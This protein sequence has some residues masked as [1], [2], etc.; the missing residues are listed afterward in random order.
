[1]KIKSADEVREVFDN[2][3]LNE[4][5][6]HVDDESTPKKKGMMEFNTQNVLLAS[7]KLLSI[8][9]EAIGTQQQQ[10]RENLEE[11]VA[12]GMKNI[13][14]QLE[15]FAK[16]QEETQKRTNVYLFSPAGQPLCDKVVVATRDNS[17]K[18]EDTSPKKKE[19]PG[20]FSVQ[21]IVRGLYVGEVMCDLGSIAIMMLLSLFNK[22]GGIEAEG[23]IIIKSGEDYITYRISGQYC[24]LKQKGVPKE[25]TNLKID[26]QEEIKYLRKSFQAFTVDASLPLHLRA[27]YF[28]GLA[29]DGTYRITISFPN[30]KTGEIQTKYIHVTTRVG[31]CHHQCDERRPEHNSRKEIMQIGKARHLKEGGNLFPSSKT[32]YNEENTKTGEENRH[33]STEFTLKCRGTFKKRL[34][35]L[36][37]VHPCSI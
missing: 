29:T 36:R 27:R 33:F 28:L 22:I 4:Y 34:G 32:S 10:L 31:K 1:M 20:C 35:A 25:E 3:S 30:S 23:E 6:A 5:S 17:K 15:R 16:D 8:Q 26:D 19:N 11:L 24:C 13:Q 21:V 14:D 18:Y 7:N 2:M 12:H 37:R 9:L